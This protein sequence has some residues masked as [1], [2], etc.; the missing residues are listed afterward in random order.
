MG[1]S[2]SDVFVPE[3]A[4]DTIIAGISDEGM[5]VLFGSE[6]VATDGTLVS[7]GE[8]KVG[9]KLKVPYFG[10]IPNL[11]LDVPE[12]IALDTDKA[13]ETVEEAEIQRAGVAIEY[14]TWAEMVLKGRR[15]GIDPYTLFSAQARDRIKQM[16]ERKLVTTART[17][18]SSDYINDVSGASKTID[19]D[20]W[21]DTRSLLGDASKKIVM[22]SVH[23][24]VFT[25]MVKLKDSTNRPLLVDPYTGGATIP[26]FQG[27]PV[28]ESDF[29]YKSSDSPAKYDSLL[30][31][32]GALAL[33]Y[34]EPTVDLDVAPRSGTKA[35]VIWVYYIAYRYKHLPGGTKPGV[36]IL[37]SR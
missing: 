12:G 21:A 4:R 27:V 34:S 30:L 37:R 35:I 16:F 14:S 19:W 24:K 9:R 32:R 22:S 1:V 26:K 5:P 6:A 17:G 36:L 7:Q 15:Q 31:Q 25:D 3:V 11:Q 13:S 8:L 20:I 23:S 18:L 33:W 28:F 10:M 29:N 2:T